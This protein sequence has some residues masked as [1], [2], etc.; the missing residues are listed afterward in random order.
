MRDLFIINLKG[1]RKKDDTRIKRFNEEW[2]YTYTEEVDTLRVMGN[3]AYKSP[4]SNSVIKLSVTKNKNGRTNALVIQTNEGGTVINDP[5]GIDK[6][7]D[8]LMEYK[9]TMYLYYPQI[10]LSTWEQK[11]VLRIVLSLEQHLNY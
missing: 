11:K 4:I 3:D 5:A 8:W 7:I 6:L 9:D 1:T 10:K 2:E